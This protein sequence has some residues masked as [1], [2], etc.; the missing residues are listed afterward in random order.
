MSSPEST[1]TEPYPDWTPNDGWNEC[2]YCGEAVQAPA[3][4]CC[5][6]HAEGRRMDR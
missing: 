1:R 2:L 4:Y 5:E 6:E 3:L